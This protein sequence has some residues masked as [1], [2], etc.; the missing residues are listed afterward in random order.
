MR[1]G[2]RC[3]SGQ[4]SPAAEHAMQDRNVAMARNEQ[5]R[6]GVTAQVAQCPL[7]P[8]CPG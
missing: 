8:G 7:P 4:T 6:T 1:A 3:T 2:S 5:L